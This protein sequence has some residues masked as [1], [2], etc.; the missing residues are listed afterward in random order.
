MSGKPS[1][2]GLPAN[3]FGSCPGVI[4]QHPG[5]HGIDHRLSE[6]ITEREVGL[7]ETVVGGPL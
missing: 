7:Q 5:D 1:F 6:A 4:G 3:A 2:P